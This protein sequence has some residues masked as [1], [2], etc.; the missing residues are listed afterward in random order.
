MQG[1][2]DTDSPDSQNQA[3]ENCLSW[4]PTFSPPLH[5]F[6]FCF[7][8]RPNHRF[9]WGVGVEVG[10]KALVELGT[11]LIVFFKRYNCKHTQTFLKKYVY[12]SLS[13]AVSGSYVP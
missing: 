13:L 4:E 12:K 2:L 3:K 7:Y 8:F 1:P 10:W 6:P 9:F 11:V 5:F